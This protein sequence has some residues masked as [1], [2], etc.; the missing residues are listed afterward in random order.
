MEKA[1]QKKENNICEYIIHMYQTEDLLRAY[2]FDLESIK[3]H[4]I[5]HLPVEESEKESFL[6][7]YDK[8]RKEM[9]QEEI[10]ITGHLN[11]VQEYVN[12][13]T[14]L[15]N[16]LMVND[17]E[18]QAIYKKAKPHIDHH[19]EL[20]KGKLTNPIQICLNGVYGL[21]LLRLNGKKIE[22]ELTSRIDS[23]G[24]VLSYL[25]YQFKHS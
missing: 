20:S 2:N 16:Q 25:A 18:Y 15:H 23:F 12:Q 14:D 3:L 7:W 9:E 8:I 11:R 21:L 6:G 13:L 4:V 1:D 5:A 22:E 17:G 10:T 24:D 19:L